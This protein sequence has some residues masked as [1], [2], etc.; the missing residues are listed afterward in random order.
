LQKEDRVFR[1]L[2]SGAGIAGLALANSL[3]NSGCQISV[4]E[5]ASTLRIGGQAIDVRGAAL[6]VIGRLGLSD[7][8]RARRIETNGL[9]MLN[10]DGEV[11][12]ETGERT[13]T[14]GFFA[15]DD[16]EIIRDD[17]VELLAES[18]EPGIDLH[19]SDAIADIAQD[20]EGINVTTRAGHEMAFDLVIGADGVGS[21]VRK[22]AFGDDA[23][24]LRFLNKCVAN[25]T[26]PNSIG[27]DQWQFACWEGDTRWIVYPSRENRDLR[28]FLMFDRAPDQIMPREQNEQIDL[29][30]SKISHFPWKIPQ[31][32]GDPTHYL[33]F[34]FG[35]LAVV[36][37]P[38]WSAGRVVLVGDAG[39]C[40]TPL[41]GQGTSLALVG[42]YLLG[43]ELRKC[44]GDFA[45]A[46]GRYEE[47]MRPFVAANL[48][49]LG[50]G[51]NGQQGESRERLKKAKS[52][53]DIDD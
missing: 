53:I 23:G 7:A 30:M 42:A 18:A 48:G 46:F 27:L 3:K 22:L 38:R 29:V 50:A 35:D 1:I 24:N 11:L 44:G 21:T 8:L 4:I 16:I 2:I 31:L 37:L 40:P 41:T 26:V 43:Q 25:I 51:D 19:F 10:A 17:L 49:L 52:A 47:R 36:D 32:L 45:R 9:T 28:I 34:Y 15:D 20:A 14:G 39:Y 5:Q 33:Q 13:L 12:S 6:D